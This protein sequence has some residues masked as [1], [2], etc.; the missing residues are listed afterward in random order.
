MARAI[1]DTA[2][3]KEISFLAASIS[4]YTLVSLI[5]LLVLGVV[6]T[7]A[8]G[9]EALQTQLQSIVDQYLL[10]AGQGLVEE[11]LSDR[12]GQG[13]VGAVSL[14]LTLWG[15]LKLFRGLDIAFSRI[16]GSEA[17]GLVDQLRDGSIA[18]GSIGLG[19]LGVAAL[20]ALLSFL[21]VPFVQFLSPLLLLLTLCAAFFPLYYVF[22]DVGLSARQVVPGTVF[23][24]VGW[25]A[26]GIGFG[27]YAQV[28]G[29]SVAGALGSILLLVTWFYFSGLILLFGAVINAVTAGVVNST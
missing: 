29:S 5:P 10:P 8:V 14:G 17:G 16:Y 25:T 6:V 26:L 20:T 9:G 21:Q 22:P 28:A 12:A 19:T 23:A 27:I 7:T 2:R 11:A 24:A 18:L 3:E 4:Y 15:A 13:S 1:I